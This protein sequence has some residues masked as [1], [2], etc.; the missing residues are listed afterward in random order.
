MILPERP[1]QRRDPHSP[2]VPTSAIV[3][4]R[5]HGSLRAQSTRCDT[6]TSRESRN[7]MAEFDDVLR[8]EPEPTESRASHPYL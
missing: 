2:R 6:A 5:G 3:A 7:G 1:S 4:G 8:E